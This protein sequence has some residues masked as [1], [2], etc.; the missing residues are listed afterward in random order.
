MWMLFPSPIWES[1]Q[2]FSSALADSIN[3]PF[4]ATDQVHECSMDSKFC[5]HVDKGTMGEPRPCY[6]CEDA[7]CWL[8]A[9]NLHDTTSAAD[10]ASARLFRCTIQEG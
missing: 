8:T 10:S 4:L 3:L 7:M 1:F 9:L 6:A 5:D 2:G